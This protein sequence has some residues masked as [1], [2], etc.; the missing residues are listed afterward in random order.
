MENFYIS[1]RNADEVSWN[2]LSAEEQMQFSKAIETEWQGVLDFK[3]A[4]IIDSTQADMIREKHRERVISSRLVLRWKETDTGYKAKARWCVHGFKDL[5]IHEIER[6]CPTPKL[7]SI[8][9]ALQILASTTSEETL[10]DGKKAFMQG[11]PSVRD[12]PPYATPPPERLPVPEGA[13]IRLNREVFGLVSGMSGWRSRIVSKLKEE[14]YEMNVYEPCL[15]SKFA[16]REEPAVDGGSI[17]PGEFVGCVF[18]EVGDH[19]MGVLEKHITEAW[20]DYGRGSSLGSG[21]GC[22][23]T[24][25]LFFGGR[26]FTQLPDRSFKVD[27]TRFIRERLRPISLPRG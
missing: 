13:L 1:R 11:D 23:K 25:R 15:F 6:R 4:M 24:R 16:V 3:A 12:E 7:S 19:L 14:G 8:N 27:M 17:A 21:T 10:A 26:H 22:C 9:N 18:L 2:R 5:D 20:R